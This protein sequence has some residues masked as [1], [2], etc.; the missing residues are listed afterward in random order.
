MTLYP[1]QILGVADRVGSIE[2]GKDATIFVTDGDPLEIRTKI[3]QVFIQGRRVDLDDRHK[4]L[5]RRYTEKY[6]QLGTSLRK[7]S[8]PKVPLPKGKS[9]GGK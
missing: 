6:R 8:A 7:V 5:Y 1:A 3:E 9:A 2:L 4:Q